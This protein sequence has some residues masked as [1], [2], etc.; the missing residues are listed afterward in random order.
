[1]TVPSHPASLDASSCCSPMCPLG[2]LG[3]TATESLENLKQG[4]QLKMSFQARRLL[5]KGW[6]PPPVQRTQCACTRAC[7]ALGLSQAK[8]LSFPYHMVPL[9]L[10]TWRG[11]PLH[12]SLSFLTLFWNQAERTLAWAPLFFFSC[13]PSLQF[14]KCYDRMVA[15]IKS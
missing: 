14:S 7:A 10:T 2:S 11:L 4:S 9:G 15:K 1:M 5:L 6:A 3:R 13:G 8:C 12:G